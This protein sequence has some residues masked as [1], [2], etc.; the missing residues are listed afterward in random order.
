MTSFN[1]ASV[2]RTGCGDESRA[3]RSGQISC[4]LI[5]RWV[6]PDWL[7][8]TSS[9]GGGGRAAGGGVELQQQLVEAVFEGRVEAVRALVGLGAD[10]HAKM[11]DGST[12]LHGAATLGHGEVLR[13]L[14]ELGADV[15]AQAQDGAT[16]LHMAA[17]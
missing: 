15:H 4:G 9:A 17:H 5:R 10:V 7:Q 14:V 1:C 16:P 8:A 2:G 12:M 11:P 13:A 6:V 3:A